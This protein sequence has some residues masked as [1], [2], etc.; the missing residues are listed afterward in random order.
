LPHF[1]VRITIGLLRLWRRITESA[2]KAP[3][4]VSVAIAF[5]LTAAGSGT[6]Q[7][8]KPPDYASKPVAKWIEALKDQNNSK[9]AAEARKALGPHGPYA[10]TAI[11][12][13]IDALDER[14]WTIRQEVAATLADYGR[15]IVNRLILALNRPE[16][17]V[18]AGAAEALGYV[19]PRAVDAVR[20]LIDAMRERDTFAHVFAYRSLVAI[21]L[22]ANQTVADSIAAALQDGDYRVRVQVLLAL[23]TM[24]HKTATAVP[25][26]IIA[27][28]DKATLQLH[29]S[30]VEILGRIGPAA[31]DAVPALIEALGSK[32]L[33]YDRWRI[34][35]TLGQIGP[36]AKAA[37]PALL[38]VLR[39]GDKD[40]TVTTI[41][42]LGYIGPGAK[43]AVPELLKI[44]KG[45]DQKVR[46]EAISALGEIGPAS[47]DAVPIMIEALDI[48]KP[49][50]DADTIVAALGGVGPDAKAAVPALMAL[51]RDL[52]A[53]SFLREQAARAIT[54]I[55]PELA[56]KEKMEI[57]YLNIRLGKIPVVKLEPR[58]AL[59]EGKKKLIRRLIAQLAEIKEPDYGMAA[60]NGRAFAPVADQS[61]F[62]GGILPNRPPQSF[63]A[64]R[65]LVELG[66][67][68]LPFLLDALGDKRPTQMNM[69]SGNGNGSYWFGSGLKGNLLNPLE[70]HLL[71]QRTAE[72]DTNDDTLIDDPYT[73]RVGD[74]CF[75]AIGQIVGR[76]YNTVTWQVF[77]IVTSPV[78]T[79]NLRT[80]VRA[81]WES[82]DPATKLL[83]SL[84][85][86]YATEG[87]FNGDSLDGWDKG[88]DYQVQAALRLLYY[89]PKEAAPLIAARLRSF[90]VKEVKD[91]D[92]RMKREVNNGV[93]TVNF[94]RA[95]SWCQAPEIKK[96]LAD[97][98]KRTDDPGI[99]ELVIPKKE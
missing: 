11:P 57:A 71:S 79:K 44:A 9:I 74:V 54:A 87:I 39:E 8:E 92:A 83:D 24:D 2:M 17:L 47:K 25:G 69:K 51:V 77:T 3:F 59:T 52:Q 19:R 18:R 72:A 58:P 63:E 80:H 93:R 97:I 21:G 98:G 60:F 48:H 56:A 16:N 67:E 35:W 50:A 42:A 96:A 20:A 75:V 45:K 4:L 31:K 68:A 12:A 43:A 73:L 37:V 76:P 22:P 29:F 33:T 55:D 26:L 15:P 70:R 82:D 5:F 14:D 1:V 62:A 41:R 88:S 38:D 40:F 66:P 94:I 81:L 32:E 89:F 34:V 86:D 10:K 78:V 49:Y 90:D 53:E 28:K 61:Q 23:Y 65:S 99:K 84:L 7:V 6:A 91:K 13:L 46:L 64:F 27:M 36:E 95:V 85:I 30:A